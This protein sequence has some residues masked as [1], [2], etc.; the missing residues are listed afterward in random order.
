LIR[1]SK[2]QN[3]LM[4]LKIGGSTSKVIYS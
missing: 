3:V 1:L 2:L 4:W